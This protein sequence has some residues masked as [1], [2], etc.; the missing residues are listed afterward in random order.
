MVKD[1]ILR[2]LSA[3]KSGYVS[4]G[5]LAKKLKV[6]RTA[7]WKH[8]RALIRDGYDIEAV[9]SKGYRF[10][11]KPDRIDLS[12]LRQALVAK[13][14]GSEIQLLNETPS[15]NTRAM[16]MAQAGAGE[17]IVVIAETQT[18]GRGRLGREWAS[19]PGNIYMSV[20]LR[21]QLPPY[22]APLV[23]LAAAV[24][25]ASAIRK[26]VDVIAEIKWPNDIF[27][28]GRKI[29][30][31]LTE[32]SAEPD[33]VKHIIL[34]VGIN[35]N[36]DTAKLPRGIRNLATSLSKEAGRKIDRSLL[37][38]YVLNEL[39]R[40]YHVLQ[41]DEALVLK[42]WEGLNMTIGRR[43][44]VSGPFGRLEGMA[45]GIDHE[46]RLIL[47]LDDNTLRTVAAGDVTILKGLET[48]Q[49]DLRRRKDAFGN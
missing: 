34:G 17:G 14:L 3:P 33:R 40:W 41:R 39:E 11:A 24:A 5:E 25:V 30:G 42:E 26:G 12:I 27:V 7:V 44:A 49:H 28:R 35:V 22:K 29:G 31:I 18:A 1:D 10:I 36:M 19:P 43:V 8:I 38:A 15:T 4:G 32:M 6:S 45:E 9:P 20:V 23:T 37:V 46:G 13:V 21:P 16:E 2:L 48:G 47:R